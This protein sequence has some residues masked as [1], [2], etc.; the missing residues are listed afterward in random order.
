MNKVDALVL[1]FCDECAE[2][3]RKKNIKQEAVIPA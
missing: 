1:Y 2:K 3:W